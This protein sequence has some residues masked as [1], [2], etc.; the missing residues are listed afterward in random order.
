MGDDT[1]SS[2]GWFETYHEE[3]RKRLALEKELEEAKKQIEIEHQSCL[4]AVEINKSMAREIDR[5][6]ALL[7]RYSHPD[8]GVCIKCAHSEENEL[9][10]PCKT[11]SQ[12]NYTLWEPE[13]EV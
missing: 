9:I 5:V 7:K 12:Q 4:Q 11:C 13:I 8:F 1:M 3:R 2:Q 10:E 6:N